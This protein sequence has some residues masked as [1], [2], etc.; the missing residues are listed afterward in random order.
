[1]L[2]GHKV[3]V[4]TPAGRRRFLPIIQHYIMRESIHGSGVIDEW[5]LWINTKDQADIDLMEDMATANP[6]FIKCQYSEDGPLG[7][8]GDMSAIRSFYTKETLDPDAVYLRIDDDIVFVDTDAFKTLARFRLDNLHYFCITANMVN[9]GLCSHLHDRMGMHQPMDRVLW[10]SEGGP[11]HWSVNMATLIHDTFIRDIHGGRVDAWKQYERWELWENPR[12]GI[13]CTAY[14]GKDLLALLGKW[15]GDE[16]ETFF[17]EI[18]PRRIKRINAICGKSL[19]AHYAYFPQRDNGMETQQRPIK[20]GNDGLI[21]A[22]I[23]VR[24][25]KLAGVNL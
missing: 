14:L 15:E 4:V 21:P 17:T 9:S 8:I 13:A 20:P 5:R 6:D 25:K 2:N 23:L 22:N 3:I 18:W 7:N 10:S 11:L 1:M 12:F 16:D 24:Y 19:M